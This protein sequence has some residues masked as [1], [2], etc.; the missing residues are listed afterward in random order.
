MK[1]GDLHHRTRIVT[2]RASSTARMTICQLEL[3]KFAAVSTRIFIRAWKMSDRQSTVASR[4]LPIAHHFIL[5]LI[6][7]LVLHN[8][9]SRSRSRSRCR[10]CCFCCC[11]SR[12][13]SRYPYYYYYHCCYY[14]FRCY[15]CYA[16]VV[17]ILYLFEVV[18]VYLHSYYLF[19]LYISCV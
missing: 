16:V 9:H 6:N 18:H 5:L 15:K 17:I 13:Y 1:N 8:S 3:A 19:A 2:P 12:H 4:L 7:L 14:Y 10:P 11:S